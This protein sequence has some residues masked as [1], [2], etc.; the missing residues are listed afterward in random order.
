MQVPEIFGD[1]VFVIED[2]M[3]KRFDDRVDIW[4]PTKREALV[5]GKKLTSVEILLD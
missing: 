3:H 5:F 4:M 2:R 1:E